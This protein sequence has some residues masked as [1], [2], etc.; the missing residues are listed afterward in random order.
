MLVLGWGNIF[1]HVYTIIYTEINIP[2]WTE[3]N[4]INKT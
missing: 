2:I 3:K 4:I 1:I